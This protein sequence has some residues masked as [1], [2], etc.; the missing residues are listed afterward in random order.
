MLRA[1]L[2]AILALLTTACGRNDDSTPPAAPPDPSMAGTPAPASSAPAPTENATVQLAPTQGNS[3]TGSL[4]AEAVADGVRFTGTLQ[5]LK[6]DSEFG[7][8]VHENGDCSAPDASSAGAHFNPAQAQHGD[9]A[10]GTAHHA[11]DMLN[12][13]S[14]AQGVAQVDTT[15]KGTTLSSGQPTD[16]VGKAVVVHAGP[17]DYNT[18]PSGNSGARIACGVISIVTDATTQTQ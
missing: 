1:S 2:I 10:A 12:V 8:H 9:P 7:F 3:V 11:G 13:R 4:S 16:V 6:P 18:Q 17:D 15:A 5:G 14:D